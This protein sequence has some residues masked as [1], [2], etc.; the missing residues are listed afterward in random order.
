MPP[1]PLYDYTNHHQKYSFDDFVGHRGNRVAAAALDAQLA[2][3]YRGGGGVGRADIVRCIEPSLEHEIPTS[4][5]T[6]A[7]KRKGNGKSRLRN[8]L[9]AIFNTNSSISSAKS[10]QKASTT[11]TNN[12]NSNIIGNSLQQSFH[13]QGHHNANTFHHYPISTPNNHSIGTHSKSQHLNLMQRQKPT[14]VGDIIS[15]PNTP[16]T[17]RTISTNSLKRVRSSQLTAQQTSYEAMRTIDMYLIRQIARS[18]MVSSSL[19]LMLAYNYVR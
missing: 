19:L 2:A 9:A 5:T 4:I 6:P 7:T 16:R 18:C 15:A 8:L 13:Q 3:N 1:Q 17:P 14:T 11:T 12:I 10:K